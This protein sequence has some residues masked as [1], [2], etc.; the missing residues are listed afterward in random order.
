MK[1]IVH[2]FLPLCIFSFI[3]FG[4]S[5][6]F[7]DH[8]NINDTLTE[9]ITVIT[10]EFSNIDVSS[11][12]INI[13]VFPSDRHD[14]VVYANAGALDEISAVVANGT[15]CI[16]CEKNIDSFDDFVDTFRDKGNNFVEI[17]VPTAVYDSITAKVNA[18]VTEIIGISAEAVDLRLNAGDLTF[19]AP[20]GYITPMLC[21][22]LNAGNCTL[23]NAQSETFTLDLS[24]GNMDIYGLSGNGSIDMTAGT[25][26][27]NF[28]RLDGDI[29]IDASA[30]SVNINLP[31]DASF[32]V[33][34]EKTAGDV[35]IKHGKVKDSLDDGDNKSVNGGQYGITC[36]LTAGEVNITDNI[37]TKTAPA[38]PEAKPVETADS[39]VAAMSAAVT[40]AIHKEPVI[41]ADDVEVYVD[42]DAGLSFP[43]VKVDGDN[44]NVDLGIIEVD[45]N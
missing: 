14:T 18:G 22:E 8:N 13:R 30:G 39:T 27:A 23:Y 43:S 6:I 29:N 5:L 37:K 45:V 21:A 35:T 28:A 26:S 10:E 12:G 41:K 16:D 9:E 11:D 19:A 40:T 42:E 20:E 25:V 4:L 33:Y 3:A 17:A 2:F 31:V 36:D 34:C 24:A 15:L 44:V 32:D 7:L 38:I 1:A